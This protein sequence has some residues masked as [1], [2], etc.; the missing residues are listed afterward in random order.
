MPDFIP[1]S[2]CLLQQASQSKSISTFLSIRKSRVVL[3]SCRIASAQ[4]MAP[5]YPYPY[6]PTRLLH[7][8]IERPLLAKM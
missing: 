2:R 7:L 5:I 3:F 4:L 8:E 6:H 1:T